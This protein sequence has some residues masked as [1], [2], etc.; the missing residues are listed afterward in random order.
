MG[1]VGAVALT[2]IVVAVVM[3]RAYAPDAPPL[4]SAASTQIMPAPAPQPVAPGAVASAPAAP[5]QPGVQPPVA[6]PD[7][8][9]SAKKGKRAGRGG[10]R[11]SK[12][13]ATTTGGAKPTPK[14][15]GDDD[16]KR[17]LGI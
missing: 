9:A 7:D 3:V 11:V 2:A 6:A 1:G 10:K 13:V 8:K 17:L 5:A 15:R 14:K 12:A 4:G 16:L